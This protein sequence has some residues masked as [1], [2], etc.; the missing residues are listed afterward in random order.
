MTGA[1]LQIVSNTGAHQN[2]WIDVEPQITYF[3]KIYRRHTPFSFE[4][5]DI[6]CTGSINFGESGN[7]Q[8]LPIGDLAYRVLF[9]Y[10]IPYMAAAFL[11]LK[12]I[13][14]ISVI[15]DSNISDSLFAS[16][17]RRF[18]GGE[19]LQIGETMNVIEDKLCC[20]DREEQVRLQILCGLNKYKDPIGFNDTD[21]FPINDP[22]FDFI[23]RETF[24]FTNFKMSLTTEWIR[25]KKEYF[26]IYKLLSFIYSANRN[27][28]RDSPIVNTNVVSSTLLYSSIFNIL[29]PNREILA[30][31]YIHSLDYSDTQQYI[32]NTV[33]EVFDIKLTDEYTGLNISKNTP[34][35]TPFKNNLEYFQFLYSIYNTEP[36]QIKNPDFEKNT[37][38]MDAYT[39]LQKMAFAGASVDDIQTN[40]YD[41][42]PS[43]YYVLNA[44]NTVINIVNNLATTT[45]IVIAKAF[46]LGTV[47][48]NIYSNTTSVPLT[49]R[50]NPTILDPNFKANWD[51]EINN[52]EKPIENSS[53]TPVAEFNTS[54]QIYPNLFISE[55]LQL[56][57]NH[58][59]FLFNNMRDGLD[60]LFEAY[61]A[62]LFTSTRT[63]FLN[64]TPPL[65]NIYSYIAPTQGFQDNSA[66]RISNVFNAN[67]WFFYFF[68]Y[69]DTFN[70]NNFVN[71]AIAN[72]TLIDLNLN[73]NS[74]LF[75]SSI[76][77][78]LKLNIDNYMHEISYMLNDLYDSAPS[79]F[80][81][82]T[83]KNYVPPAYGSTI[84]D[85]NVQNDIMGVTFIFYRNHTQ[86][87]L[88]MF[89]YIYYFID[90]ITIN[91]MNNYLGITILPISLTVMNSIREMVK[92]LYY[93]M[94]AYFMDVYD[95]FRYEPPAN[96]SMNDYDAADV[97]ALRNYVNY[98]FRNTFIQVAV[99]QR[100]VPLNETI[101][102]MEFYFVAEMLNMREL[103]K[104]YYNC[105]FNEDLIGDE[106]GSTTAM[107][108]KMV[109]EFFGAITPPINT[110]VFRFSTDTV[111][112]YWNALYDPSE[113]ELYYSTFN[114]DRYT[115]V[116][117]NLTIYES[118]DYGL[119]LLPIAPP[120][121]LPPTDPYGINPAYYDNKQVITDY[122]PVPPINTEAIDSHIPV[123][124]VSSSNTT[125]INTRS[126]VSNSEF[127]LFDI[128]YFRIKHSILH[129]PKIKIPKD[130]CFVSEYQMNILKILHLTRRLDSIY[131]AKD[132]DLIYWIWITLFF[133]KGQTNACALYTNYLGMYDL[134]TDPTFLDLLNVYFAQIYVTKK[135][136]DLVV[137]FPQSLLIE[138]INCIEQMF[139]QFNACV[140][141]QRGC[142]QCPYDY[143]TLTKANVYTYNTILAQVDTSV[144]IIDKVKIA[145]DDFL[146]QYFY[147]VKYS[148]SIIEIQNVNLINTSS[149]PN[150]PIN[151][152]FFFKNISQITYD[153]LSKINYNDVDLTP[154]QYASTFTFFFP[155]A[156]L[157][158]ATQIIETVK[159]LD[160][161]SQNVSNVLLTLMTPG[162]VAR[163][164]TKDTYD[165]LN[166]MFDSTKQ[167]YAYCVEN[168]LYDFVFGKLSVYQ[169]L[170]L[171]KMVLAEEIYKYLTAIPQNQFM[172][173][174]DAKHV[175]TLAKSYGIQCKDYYRYIMN[176]I[177]V[178][179]NNAKTETLLDPYPYQRNTL[180]GIRLSGE[181]DYFFLKWNLCLDV[182]PYVMFK[183]YIISDI[184]STLDADKNTSL[185][186]FF[187]LVDNVTFPYI[188]IFFKYVR[189]Y[190]LKLECIINPISLS[191]KFDL[192]R[193][194][195]IISLYY[196]SFYALSDA[197]GY[198]MD[199]IWDWMMTLCNDD[200]YLVINDFGYPDRPSV[201]VNQMHLENVL[202]N[203][204]NNVNECSLLQED[205]TVNRYYFKKLV[206]RNEIVTFIK[207]VCCR[208]IVLL[209]TRRTELIAMK[210]SMYNIFYRN[211]RAKM[212]WIRKLAH[213]LLF[214]VTV[215]N[216]D[217]IMDSHQSDFI[218]AFHEVTKMDGNENGYRKMIGDREDLTI[219][220]NE[221]K[222]S[223]L[224][225]MPLV[226]YFNRNPIC[227]LPLSA[228][229]NMPYDITIEL[230]PLNE[231][232]YKEQFASFIDPTLYYRINDPDVILEPFI[233]K[234]MN[235]YI[236][237]E[238]IFLTTDER[239]IFVTNMLQYIMEEVQD[240]DGYSVTGQSLLPI[241]KIAT[242]KKMYDTIR[243]GKK[244]RE[245]Y[246][247]PYK[248]VF[249]DQIELDKITYQSMPTEC[250][251]TCQPTT[252]NN[253]LNAGIDFIPRNDYMLEPYTNKS[254]ICQHMMINR[255]LSD[256]DPDLDP[257]IH[258]KRVEYQHFFNNPTELMFTLVKLDVH[259]Q[260]IGRE[261]EKSYFYGEHQWDNYGIYSHFDLSK[262]Y[263]AKEK[264]YCQLQ[265]KLNDPD[266]PAYGIITVIDK[267]LCTYANL[268]DVPPEVDATDIEQFIQDNI[269]EFIA[270]LQRI[271]C[272]YI[273]YECIFGDFEK[274]IRLKE[275][276]MYLALDYEI[277]Q[278]NFLF[279]MVA[280]VYDQLNI[281]PV[282]SDQEVAVVYATLISGF[283]IC[284]FTMT[285]VQFHAGMLLMLARYL[286]SGI[287]TTFEIQVATNLIYA[288]YNEAEVNYLI[289]IVGQTFDI[290]ILTYSFVNFV[291]YYYN[292]YNLS[293]ERVPAIVQMLLQ[294]NTR[295]NLSPTKEYDF[296]NSYPIQDI[297]YKNIVYQVI[298]IISGDNPFVD[299]MTLI[300]FRMLKVVTR[301]MNEQVNTIV[302]TKW[303]KLIN[304]QE[305][306]IVNPKVNPL[307]RGYMTFNS[308]TVMPNSD[309][310]V[311]CEMN[312]YRYLLHTPSVGINTYSWALNPLLS[313]PTGSANFSRIDDFRSILYLHPLIGTKYPATIRTIML[314]INL[315]RYL[316]GLSGKTWENPK[317]SSA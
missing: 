252:T 231:V 269:E 297:F 265:V 287:L 268:D 45:P 204:E 22:V 140:T 251:I 308:Y 188:Y 172:T 153:I 74:L 296:L 28:V 30:M 29:I 147:Y 205:Q 193:D 72:T 35:D 206:E 151:K 32:T 20:Y 131:P 261:N 79:T 46:N 15:N 201:I 110:T 87:I 220:D 295:L 57:N 5:V 174:K 84:N 10:S 171:N 92:L 283:D 313:Q 248:G 85:V 61:R 127:Q 163:L 89:E 58:F 16:K 288:D 255:P 186:L 78:L 164:T 23:R 271:K 160:D 158:D 136:N 266:D 199:L 168:G 294:I 223:Y 6:P 298:P 75:M 24:D 293:A 250:K 280:D 310:L 187:K 34:A 26:P 314:S 214:D 98:F 77:A 97:T 203:L 59:A 278:S 239:K 154:L 94:F 21:T 145:R 216:G 2:R 192:L 114:L 272:A 226:F 115:G 182:T 11:N 143:Q 88:E 91:Q 309:G 64:N 76:I 63:L 126:P 246:Y 235:S 254:G 257:N 132:D 73:S 8:I 229:L 244:I 109:K 124:W 219:F 275:N 25:E 210:N 232:T 170:M 191:D 142:Q 47:P 259:T 197:L 33:T 289:S 50:V 196:R 65:Q 245:E 117:Y 242:T 133:L 71:Y 267:L 157:A 69:L 18:V 56:I 286:E 225:T 149:T 228:S 183:D 155:D 315:M 152:S 17:I 194:Q 301:K 185:V 300:P 281:A 90:N 213:F 207:D 279:Q 167:N 198:Y 291:D 100:Q 19:Q 236:T 14:L 299:Y 44:Y 247:D 7:A 215:R 161:F 307:L 9:S 277:W 195:E 104:F 282:P 103:E 48:V 3:K 67:I 218:E 177:F 156:F 102:Q 68:K 173:K 306:M 60:I 317:L 284:N 80:N 105:V 134:G 217:Q 179:F 53:F 141:I 190:N 62:R 166:I 227:A 212:A 119:V 38:E 130:V 222:K 165:L 54:D 184:F 234:I 224:I 39:L 135:S 52:I 129:K 175:A 303:V 273:K 316:S 249:I 36:T 81:T 144:N 243:D 230:R 42:G 118:R 181:L 107:L 304:Y 211:K 189:K 49:S 292:L 1:I 150:V 66:K 93:S 51:F 274:T 276:I 31:Y 128:D 111:R 202:S 4:L 113:R 95:S 285:K 12:T 180:I 37:I 312:A 148:N 121:P 270:T 116:P 178:P 200:P 240:D 305:N 83:M 169:P 256:M 253:Y 209:Q 233:P 290:N 125:N 264:Y 40:F 123:Y 82:D 311:W 221:L 241:Y 122:S 41:Y 260:P 55:Y 138:A 43:F 262:I 13:D 176:N 120:V 137:T 258:Q 106:V 27:I 139:N 101:A 86:T 70:E 238:Y 96:Y 302:N 112:K 263:C 108:I 237:V 162:T 99:N 208:G 146:S 159:K